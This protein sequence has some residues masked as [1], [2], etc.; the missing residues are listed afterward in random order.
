MKFISPHAVRTLR[1]PFALCF[2][3]VAFSCFA[4]SPQTPPAAQ[5]G[6]A[7]ATHGQVIFSRSTDENGQTTTVAGPAAQASGGKSVNAPVASD[8]ERRAVTF[9][10]FDLD[11]HLRLVEHHIAVRALLTVRNDGSAPLAHIPLQLSS[12]LTWERIHVVGRDVA[13]T[14]ATLNSDVDHTGQLHEAAVTLA[15]PLAPGASLQ[16]DVTYSGPITQNAQRLLAIGTPEDA[17]LHSD[18]D[19][20]GTG[21]TGLRGFGNVVW[22]PASSVPVIL[23][24][25]ARVFDEMGEHKLRISGARFH[26]H[27]TAEFPHGQAPT[28]ALINGH[29]APL[30][31]TDAPTEGAEVSGIATASADQSF[32]GFEA[33]SIFL[34]AR[35]VKHAENTDL[36]VLPAD[37]AAVED[38][39]A[40][41]AV[42]TPFLQS[43]LGAKPRSRL[44]ILDLP[45]ADD[46]P[47][48]TGSL[49]VVAIQQATPEQLD[50]VFAH[51]LTHAWMESPRAW[52]SEGVAHFMGTLWIEHESGRQKALEALAADRAALSLVE[53]LSPGESSGQP[54][55]QA[56]APIYYREKAT[57]IFWMLRD[58]V[59]DQVLSAAFRAYSPTADAALGLGRNSGSGTFE[60]LLTTAAAAP[61]QSSSSQAGISVNGSLPTGAPANVRRDLSWFFADWIDADKG[62][63]DLSIGNV[64][65][66]PTDAG[67]W[68]VTVNVANVGYAGAEIPVTVSSALTSITE[69]I[70]VPGRGTAVQR[71]LIQGEPTK[72]QA[73]DGIVP[74]IEASVHIKTLEDTSAGSSQIAPQ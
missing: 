25:G 47:F 3:L 51:A 74:E 68:L 63:A 6:Q 24:D 23:G 64:F 16:L 31:I 38:W 20:I 48:E 73:N 8:A 27:L 17:A 43:W 35:T 54:L 39:S 10:A 62:L 45:D 21:F 55:G 9:T 66:V 28:V 42:V 12:S 60:K 26:L 11:V 72:V 59:G 36:F 15:Q 61:A 5:P 19:C 14:V 22:Y 32:L 7:P 34:A 40:S 57:Y 33:P 37:E 56:I 69:R 41:A 53:P 52:I 13:F 29:L 50:G 49:L 30:T 65:T 44:A 67:N 58:L 70:L 4:Q 71:I 2:W 46:A 18:W 1:R